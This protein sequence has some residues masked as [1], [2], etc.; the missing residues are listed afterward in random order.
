MQIF[1]QKN[2]HKVES[3]SKHKFRL[4]REKIVTLQVR[5]VGSLSE[6]HFWLN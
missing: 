4:C 3:T 6:A 5:A 1:P 2:S